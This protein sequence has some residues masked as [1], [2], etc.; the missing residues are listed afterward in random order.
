[1]N[2]SRARGCH[3]HEIWKASPF[4]LALEESQSLFS[5]LTGIGKSNKYE[6][7]F[8]GHKGSILR[9]EMILEAKILHLVLHF[10]THH[11]IVGKAGYVL[12]GPEVFANKFLTF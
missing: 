1:M 2:E 4:G 8:H 5:N 6:F 7:Q 9:H 10:C 3:I 12:P 11:S